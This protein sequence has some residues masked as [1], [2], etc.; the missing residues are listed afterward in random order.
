[1][2]LVGFNL[3]R[4]N[5]GRLIGGQSF[6]VLFALI[7]RVILP[8]CA[9]LCVYGLYFRNISVTSLLMVSNFEGRFHSFLTPYW[10]MEA[11]LQCTLMLVLLFRLRSVRSEEHTSELQSLMR[12]S[13]AVFCLKKKKTIIIK[14]H[15]NT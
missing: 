9:I 13:Y 14:T 2:L 1:M 7:R 15:Y 8:Y 10:F 12:I 5:F 6:D 11:L 3:A 4:F